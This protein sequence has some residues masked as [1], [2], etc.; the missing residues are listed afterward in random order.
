MNN[1]FSDEKRVEFERVSDLIIETKK[2]LKNEFFGIDEQIDEIFN[3]L[4]AWLHFP[5]LQNR[6]L[7]INLWGMTGC[8]KTSLINRLVELLDLKNNYFYFNF[9]EIFD[10]SIYEIEE[11]INDELKVTNVKTP[12]FV[13]DEF[14]Y[15]RTL[16][17]D[18]KE[19]NNSAM[20]VFW[21]LL[22]SGIHRQKH[23]VYDKNQILLL[24][25]IMLEVTNNPNII[26]ENGEIVNGYNDWVSILYEIDISLYYLVTSV[27]KKD[28]N[29]DSFKNTLN[30]TDRDFDTFIPVDK[31]N[32]MVSIIQNSTHEE[33]KTISSGII[34]DRIKK[35]DKHQIYE[36]VAEVKKLSMTDIE[37]DFTK[38]IIFVLGNIDEAYKISNNVSPDMSA[39]QFHKIT[40][41]LNTVD[42]KKAL[43]RRFR[44]EQIAR[45]GNIHLIYPAF[46]SDT[47]KK[48]INKELL[49]FSDS[50]Y[51]EYGIYFKC[52][53]SIKDI[54]YKDSVFPTQGTRPI[55][56]SI[57]ELVKSII[58]N[59]LLNSLKKNIKFSNLIYKYKRGK[60]ILEYVYKSEIVDTILIPQT[61][62]VEK[63]R[64]RKNKNLQTLVAV[65]EVGH[66]ITNLNLFKE[67]P[68]KIQSV[69]V[70]GDASGFVLFDNSNDIILNKDSL[71]KQLAV[72]L[73][74]RAAEQF[75]FGNDHITNGSQNDL[76]RVNSIANIAVR[77]WAMT[78][79]LVD[80]GWMGDGFASDDKIKDDGSLDGAIKNLIDDA[81]HLATENIKQQKG[82]FLR[83][84]E[85]LTKH[86]TISKQKLI[87]MVRKYYVGELPNCVLGKNNDSNDY[88]MKLNMMLKDL[89]KK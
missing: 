37:V 10:K 25:K 45:L 15:A 27:N 85:Y 53:E 32:R 43:Q 47:Y 42:V 59:I 5:N 67:L 77:R 68:D 41:K 20:K 2:T 72:L 60:F 48:I 51:D 75:V 35:M 18:G 19:V 46:S 78:N 21:E 64:K 73:G 69:T 57:Y 56:S 87:N 28:D 17:S 39:D 79:N 88:E 31:I 12:I 44:N 8:G 65:H 4:Q 22:D 80:I 50:L 89:D 16:D 83:L 62:R 13:Y 76:N 26:I 52:D 71:K 82:L 74:G 23:L 36:F 66:L 81:Y 40:K 55:F 6:P 86:P 24:D 30:R 63:H 61:L 11:A 70:G 1:I 38:S 84:S 9:A 34:M 14:Q 7:V 49:Q 58:P 3:N 29:D 54:I 33:S